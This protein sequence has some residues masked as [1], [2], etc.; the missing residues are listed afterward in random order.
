MVP[1]TTSITVDDRI[2]HWTNEEFMISVDEAESIAEEIRTHLDG[3]SIDGVLVDNRDADGTWPS[4]ITELW[5][6]LMGELYEAGVDCATVSPSLTNAMQ[7][8]QLAEDSGSDDRIKA[9]T[10][11]EEAV[12]FLEE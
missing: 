10:D 12:V 4:E 3:S 8:N 11:H 7:I 6:E 1:E 9:F 5:A 2:L